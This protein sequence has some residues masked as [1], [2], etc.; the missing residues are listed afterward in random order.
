MSEVMP[1]A[2]VEETPEEQW[3]GPSEQEWTQM[4]E[5]LQGIAPVL[6]MYQQYQQ[7]TEQFQAQQPPQQSPTPQVDPFADNYGEQ[8]QQLIDE[9]IQ[10]ATAPLTDLYSQV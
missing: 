8:M 9:R 7:E 10:A 3:Q 6:E 1:E 2:P 5:S 4:Q